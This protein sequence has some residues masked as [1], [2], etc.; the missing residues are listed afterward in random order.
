MSRIALE[1]FAR[2]LEAAYRGDPFHALRQNLESVR[3]EEWD[4]RPAN[5]SEEVFGTQPELSISDIVLHVGGG[6]YMY[7]ARVSGDEALD[8]AD[9]RLAPSRE[10]AAMLDWLDEGHR[11]LEAA[12]AA[13][14]DDAE[15]EVERLAPWRRPLRTEHLLSIVISH[16][17]YH[18]GEINRQRALIRGADGWG[19]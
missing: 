16:D 6:K 1:V 19:R 2:R 14:D 8:W 11:T 10:R 13:L 9:I 18:S 5:H 15:L 4:V 3:P 17:L 12:L 7:T